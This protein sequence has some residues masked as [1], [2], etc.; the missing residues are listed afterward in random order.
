MYKKFFS[1]VCII[2]P[3]IA[4]RD[5]P[6]LRSVT[7]VQ[8]I[9]EIILGYLDHYDQKVFTHTRIKKTI[10]KLLYS[11]DGTSL[12]AVYSDG[13]IETRKAKNF[14]LMRN[15]R[16]S[17]PF[18]K[19]IIYAV[20]HAHENDCIALLSNKEN[21]T[22]YPMIIEF[23]NY[24]TGKLAE[25]QVLPDSV[26][27]I[28]SSVDGAQIALCSSNRLHVMNAQCM[29]AE[30]VISCDGGTYDAAFSHDNCFIA[31]RTSF[32]SCG[33][34]VQTCQQG[35]QIF[36]IKTARKVAFLEHIGPFSLAYSRDGKYFAA[37]GDKTLKIWSADS[38]KLLYSSDKMDCE[39]LDGNYLEYSPCGK[40]FAL[41]AGNNAQI[42]CAHTQCLRYEIQNKKDI[43]KNA[44]LQTFAFSPDG[45]CLAAGYRDGSLV[46]WKNQA[47]EILSG[48]AVSTVLPKIDS[49]KP[50]CIIA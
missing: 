27:N 26:R 15:F 41:I 37:M 48:N 5:C 25:E 33:Q 24:L 17:D 34:F 40:Y 47:R 35:I 11:R 16:F 21:L 39:W 50:G 6:F 38:Y 2:F 45:T 4:Q 23:W 46:V 10:T 19:R 13:S 8:P 49:S 28:V 9:Q 7:I 32:R 30:Q 1:L 14:D 12:I 44:V 31:T 29:I 20:S 36:E 18:V 42:W 22:H 3:G 43:S